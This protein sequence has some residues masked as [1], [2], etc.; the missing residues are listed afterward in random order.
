MNKKTVIGLVILALIPALAIAGYFIYR[1]FFAG[2]IVDMSKYAVVSLEGANGHATARVS[3]D[4][5]ALGTFLKE[6]DDSTADKFIASISYSV[7]TADNHSNGDRLAI[8]AA[9]DEGLAGEL[10]LKVTSRE[11]TY[12]VSDLQDAVVLDAFK[13]IKVTTGG[14]SPYIYVNYYNESANEYLSKVNYSIDKTSGL[15]IGDTITITCMADRTAALNQ[16]Y[17]V[18][19]TEMTYTIA[20]ADRYAA[21]ASD[22]PGEELSK[23]I[24]EDIETIRR[25]TEDNTF[26]MTYTL[27]GERSYLFRDDHETISDF[28]YVGMLLAVNSLSYEREH[29]NY[30]ILIYHGSIALP[31]YDEDNPYEYVESYFA[32]TYSDA[33]ITAENEFSM[34]VNEPEM[35]YECY[36]T[37]EGLLSLIEENIGSGYN[38]SELYGQ[39]EE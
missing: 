14:I 37:Y 22:I 4:T 36:T 9:Y 21:E 8:T 33:I 30:V 35:R 18:E 6:K 2:S 3:A 31:T 15:A 7:D 38:M 25:E 17:I 20:A 16:G 26:H 27:T 28:A 5:I 29:E 23:L 10:G 13:D 1:Q 12:T 24:D 11:F 39:E 32:F 34:A 19:N